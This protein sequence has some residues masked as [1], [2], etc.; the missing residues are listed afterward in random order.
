MS[1]LSRTEFVIPSARALEF[2]VVLPGQRALYEERE[3]ILRGLWQPVLF[4]FAQSV[5]ET[6]KCVLR[7]LRTGGGD[8][9]LL[10]QGARQLA[11]R[12]V[13][14]KYADEFSERE[15]ELVGMLIACL[16]FD[17]FDGVVD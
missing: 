14:E 16:L 5:V 12:C 8:G 6:G 13:D 11:Q 15:R 1:T 2:V 17:G 4:H 10:A 9:V 3:E 7:K